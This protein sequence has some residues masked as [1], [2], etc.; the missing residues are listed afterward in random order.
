MYATEGSLEKYHL[1]PFQA[2]VD[3]ATSSIMPYYSKPSA[4]KSAPQKD[5][6]G[7]VIDFAPYGFAYNK[8]FIDTILRGQNGLQGVYQLLTQVLPATWPG[9]LRCWTSPSASAFAI[10]NAG[11]DIISGMFDVEGRPRGVQPQ[12]ERLL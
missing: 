3:C 9:A 7:N 5:P 12:Q 1:P 10:N 4:G 2:A 8:Y 6:A 11:V